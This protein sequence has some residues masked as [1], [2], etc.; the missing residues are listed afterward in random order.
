MFQYKRVGYRWKESKSASIDIKLSQRA[1]NRAD[2]LPSCNP[3]NSGKMLFLVFPLWDDPD[4]SDDECGA[5]LSMTRLDGLLHAQRLHSTSKPSND[6]R[7]LLASSH[8]ICMIL[9]GYAYNPGRLFGQTSATCPENEEGEELSL[10]PPAASAHP[11]PQRLHST[12]KPS[13]TS[14]HVVKSPGPISSD[15]PV[16]H[17]VTFREK[18]CYFYFICLERSWFHLVELH[19]T[20]LFGNFCNVGAFFTH[21]KQYSGS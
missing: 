17:A 15:I 2:Q 19:K 6:H 9:G 7:T 12:S 18:R 21:A 16:Q 10:S 11:M 20:Y 4:N 3:T 14:S 13:T 8:A 1:P 5:L